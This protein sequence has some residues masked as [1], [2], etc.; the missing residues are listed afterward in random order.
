MIGKYNLDVA[1]NQNFFPLFPIGPAIRK[2][3]AKAYNLPFSPFS[4]PKPE[5]AREEKQME[6][7]ISA[8]ILPFPLRSFHSIFFFF[9][10]R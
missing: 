10:S 7:R 3:V 6:S 4:L 5:Q 9:F 8:V 1:G 2:E